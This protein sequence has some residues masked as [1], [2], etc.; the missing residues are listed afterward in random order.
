MIETL[1]WI[2]T[3]ITLVSFTM[4]D[5]VK[6]RLI[7]GASAILWSVYG[8]LKM[9]NPLIVINLMIIVIHSYWFYKNCEGAGAGGKVEKGNFIDSSQ[10]SSES[11]NSS[12]SSEIRID[13]PTMV[14]RS[15][16]NKVNGRK[17]GDNEKV[18][19]I[20]LNHIDFMWNWIREKSG[21]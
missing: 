10:T 19:G 6:L 21:K 12:V 1:G 13:S 5:M 16:L 15:R 4:N 17:R 3:V 9:D 2:A 18:H 8:V 20:Q 14:E 11:Q 7:G